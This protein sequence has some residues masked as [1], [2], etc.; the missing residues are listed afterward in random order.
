[1]VMENGQRVIK[2][3]RYQCRPAGKPKFY[4]TKFPGTYNARRDNLEGFWRDLFGYSHGLMVVNAFFENVSRARMEGRELQDGEKDENVVLEFRP[5]TGGEMLVACL[6]SHWKA[7]GE[8]DLLSF[9]AITDEPPSEVAAAAH[10][11]CIVPI[12]PENI[13]AWLSPDPANLGALHAI[14]DDRD[15]PYYE[16]PTGGLGASGPPGRRGSARL[17]PGHKRLV[18]LLVGIADKQYRQP[19]SGVMLPAM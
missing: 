18:A 12:K 14:L 8:P 3:M 16:H 7:P 19:A 10:D 1:M 6:W 9:A 5:N 4:D 17:S 13:D 11:R 15:R 2:P